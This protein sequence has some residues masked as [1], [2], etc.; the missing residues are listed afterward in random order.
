M[1]PTIFVTQPIPEGALA[2]LREVGEVELNPDPLHIITKPELMAA[3]RMAEYLVCLLHDTIDAEVIAASPRLKLIASMAIVPAGVDVAAA[4][5]RRI[6]VTTIPPLVTE[7]T[8]DLHWALLLAVAR[9]VVEADQALRSGIFPGGQSAHLVGADVHGQTMGIIGLG[10]IGE[11]VA[12]RAR[13]FGMRILYTKRHRLDATVESSL[14][15]TYVSLDALLRESHFVSVNVV[16]TPATV[17]LI[18]PRELSLMRPSAFLINTARGPVVD[19]KALVE[20]LRS[21]TIAGV[22]LDVFEQEP[23]VEP[24]L[25]KLP[26]VVLTPHLGSAARGTRARIAA[27][28]ADNVVAAIQGR[29]PPNVYNPEVYAG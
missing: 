1:R 25:L 23:R 5:A 13:G 4:T 28:V 21:G 12:R 10:R 7:A 18:G 22:A 6:P 8:A 16:L 2:R 27:I 14:G 17:H 15:L 19:E 3:L 24:E 11:A 26:N 29:R 20:A 9:R